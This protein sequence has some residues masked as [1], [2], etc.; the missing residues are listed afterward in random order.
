MSILQ[1][2]FSLQFLFKC[3]HVTSSNHFEYIFY[4]LELQFQVE[5]CISSQRR[6]LIDLQKY[7]LF[8]IIQQNIKP[9]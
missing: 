7:R 2:N 5:I 1:F 9:K 8:S 6:V 3:I 4:E